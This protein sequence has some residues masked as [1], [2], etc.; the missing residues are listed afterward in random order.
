MTQIMIYL[1]YLSD[2]CKACRKRATAQI[3]HHDSLMWYSSSSGYTPY[4]SQQAINIAC[5]N[6]RGPVFFRQFF[7][8]YYL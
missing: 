2:V 4:P 8:L 6:H 1:I 7:P 5:F 3:F